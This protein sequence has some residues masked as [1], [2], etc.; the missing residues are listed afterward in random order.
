LNEHSQRIVFPYDNFLPCVHVRDLARLVKHLAAGPLAVAGANA[1]LRYHFAV[2]EGYF[3]QADLVQVF[4]FC[5]S[6][7]SFLVCGLCY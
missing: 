7:F 3:T 2:D 1:D 4:I 5:F 6:K